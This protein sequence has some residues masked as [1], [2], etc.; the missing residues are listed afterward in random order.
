MRWLTKMYQPYPVETVDVIPQSFPQSASIH[1]FMH[2]HPVIGQV[3][4]HL[5][6]VITIC[7]DLPFSICKSMYGP[8]IR[9]RCR[10]TTEPSRLL[11]DHLMEHLILPLYS[12]LLLWTV[13]KDPAC[14]IQNHWDTGA[15]DMLLWKVSTTVA[16][17]F[18]SAALGIS[19]LLQSTHISKCQLFLL[20]F[21]GPCL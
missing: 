2:G 3:A 11:A 13:T 8:T 12:F 14:R 4:H 10:G 9:S 7:S 20:P 5:Q 1:T 19:H 17:T 16:Q 18:A 21:Q 6:S 15:K